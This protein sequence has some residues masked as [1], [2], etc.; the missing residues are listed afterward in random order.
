EI[1]KQMSLARFP[2][3]RRIAVI[4]SRVP[5]SPHDHDRQ[6]NRVVTLELGIRSGYQAKILLALMGRSDEKIEG[7]R[8]GIAFAQLCQRCRIP[9]GAEPL[10]VEPMMD[11]DHSIAGHV[12]LPLDL[13][14]D[15][16]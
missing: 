5:L 10:M 1:S 2:D 3:E 11:D 13:G 16:L 14:R 6:Q 15:R 7:R 8:Q 4:D 9:D 12:Q